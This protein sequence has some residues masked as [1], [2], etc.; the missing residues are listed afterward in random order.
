[1]KGR[2][3]QL[4]T[5]DRAFTIE[6]ATIG[7]V[8]EAFLN[9]D[10]TCRELIDGYLAR[11]ERYD[12]SGPAINSVITINSNARDEADELDKRFKES[13]LTGP[14]HGVPV[15]LKD[16]I[17]AIGMPT[18]AGSA[19]L[20][21]C[22]S[23]EDA[24]VVK[25]L[26]E[27]GAIILAKMNMHEF[28]YGGETASTM[29]G[30]T[31]NPY[32][33]TRTPGGSS[34]GSAA[35]IAM[36]FG[37]VALGTDTVNSVRSPASACNLVGFRPSAC[38]VSK[39]G[40]IPSS[41]TQDGVGTITRTLEDAAKVLNVISGYDP[42]D[43]TTAW[44]KGRVGTPYAETCQSDLK[45]KRIGILRGFFGKEEI[46]REVNLVVDKAMEVLRTEGAVLVEI[47]DDLDA[48]KIQKEI[49]FDLLEFKAALDPYLGR[50]GPEAKIH[51][52]QE[53]I[54]AGNYYKSLD[55]TLKAA[56]KLEPYSPDYNERT[57]KRIG[58]K[59]RIV[60]ILAAHDL[61]ALMFPH[62]KRLAVKVGESQL[63][64]NGILGALTGFPA[65][66]MPGGFTAPTETAPLGIPV[67]IEFLTGEWNEPALFELLYGFEQATRH[68]SQPMLNF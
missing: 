23:R 6:E 67:G 37:L 19:N 59:N 42:A 4:E 40:V 44:S 26:K 43:P 7:S 5:Q 60:E 38:S 48:V 45:G 20:A 25:R 65:C 49:S 17:N 41:L 54:D 8:H 66:V 14:L 29:L 9:G 32:D 36:N 51:S 27:A 57:V 68:R 30:Q 47:E 35:G 10:V 50:L 3:I 64:R 58:L 13:G 33:L 12:K 21:E 46:N 31:K 28:A 15:L 39:Q 16:N 24:S 1:M 2:S 61:D 34:G 62:Q 63:E 56:V 53:L 11:I 22:V 18:T 52:L 55:G